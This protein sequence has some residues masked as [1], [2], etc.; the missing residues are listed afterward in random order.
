[1]VVIDGWE[2]FENRSDPGFVET[3]LLGL[4]RGIVTAGAPLGV[5]VV[6]I[7]GQDMLNGKLPALYSRRL[8]LP[9]P[10][11]ETRRQNIP[12]GVVSPPVLPGR[13][14]DAASGHHAQICKPSITP[15][16]LVDLATAD[17][18]ASRIDPARLP[19]RFPSL[20]VRVGLD[21]LV[22]P[23]PL[24][25]ATW[26]PLGVGQ[27]SVRTIGIDLFDPGP[28]LLLISGPAGSGR[29]TAAAVVARGL[30]R[31]GVGVVAIAPPRSPLPGLLPDDG[32]R[33]LSG[34]TIKDT[35]LREAAGAF[36]DGNYAVVVDDCEQITLTAT[37]EG[38]T[39]VPT[40]LQEIASPGA[41]GRQ[42]LILTGDAAPI[43]TGQRRSLKRVLDEVLTSGMRILLTPT[44]R[45]VAREHGFVLEPD[46]YFAG[47]PGRGHLT[48]GRDVD[49]VHLATP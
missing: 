25:S 48:T 27:A 35:D 31:A 10:K 41:M 26:I 13:A 29:T 28:N 4:L 43:L 22:L 19:H 47:P 46:Q 45:P 38:F 7:G 39:E 44:S 3:S 49:L 23:D 6:A 9:F 2:H 8:L 24:P 14:I 32:V 21:E 5:H 36:G 1:V 30:R 40:L 34:T 20:P 18:R 17:A 37:E 12:S 11:E 15:E 16:R 42:A 33:L